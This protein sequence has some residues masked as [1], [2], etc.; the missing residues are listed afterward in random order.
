M[1][2]LPHFFNDNACRLRYP[3][4]LQDNTSRVIHLEHRHDLNGD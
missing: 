4:N 2:N 3:H 1:L